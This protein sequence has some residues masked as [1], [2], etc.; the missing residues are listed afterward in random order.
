LKKS[1]LFIIILFLVS[2]IFAQEKEYNL[3]EI[4]V[5][6][7]RSPVTFNNLARSVTVLNSAEIKSLAAGSVLDIL[8]F[9]NAVDLKTRG[10]EGIQA[11]V[12]IRGGTFEQTLILIDGVKISDP[13]T[14]HHNLN[15][16]IS[17][18][19][20]ERIEI[21]KGQGS[22]IFGPNAFGGAINIITK[23]EKNSSVSISV[24][25]GQNNLYNLGLSASYPLSTT[26]NNFSFS[27][28]KSDG[29]RHNTNFDVTDFSIGQNY[30]IGKNTIN[31][32]FGYT[33][34]KFGANN[35][36]SDLYRNQWEHTT[37]KILNASSEIGIGTIIISPKI[38]WRQNTDDYILDYERPNF[39]RNNHK[40]NSYGGEIQTSLKSGIGV[41]SFGGEIN[42]EE[43]ASNN[44]GNH[45]RLKGGFF[46]EH[47]FEIT[48]SFSASAGF[49]VYNYSN[50]G[51]K[52]WPGVDAAYK[53]SEST[54]IFASVGRA[55][56]IPTFTELY[57]KS[58]ANLG[59]PDLTFEE[60]TN[61]ET[62]ISFYESA[63]KLDASIFYKKGKN[64]I[65]WARASQTE[66]WKVENVTNINTAGFEISFTYFPDFSG[67][68]IPFT[69]FNFN[70]T[71]LS[72]ER[73][74]GAF[75]SKYVLENLRHQFIANID[76]DLPFG[77][78]QSWA[79]IYRDRV[80]FEAQF[81]IDS[82]INF[83]I[84]KFNL[85]LRGTNLLNKTFEDFPGVIL[86][87]RWISCG[88]KY[89]LFDF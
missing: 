8:K 85:F 24:I 31:L 13:Q 86:P 66:P 64:I 88:V 81:T 5:S 37:T 52:I 7:G 36:Y 53:I 17:L 4:I 74:T 55:F 19:N 39:Y 18:D 60:T 2:N 20:F 9:V 44:L 82:Q 43:I 65:D 40:T 15:L 59:N 34:K 32:Y 50:I 61:Y 70:Y 77:L 51:W 83:S 87:G 41:T 28:K 11:D 89:S 27:K 45:T 3:D 33:D 73:S 12:G 30:S 49:F 46:G 72:A 10:A 38:F 67:Y 58:P 63:I 68:K 26:G 1:L 79:F 35:F 54:K 14:G 75:Q 84:N 6:A 69:K 16:P 23:K 80:N 21:L 78:T 29:Y 56:R 76:N 25:G 57:Y 42:K 47:F 22:R 62:G 48:K 71:Y